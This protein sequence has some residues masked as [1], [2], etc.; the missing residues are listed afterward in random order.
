MS[1]ALLKR[2][3]RVTGVDNLN[4][5]Y[6][7]DLKRARLSRLHCYSKFSF[8]QCDIA[9]RDGMGMIVESVP[10]TTEIV[11]FAAQAGVRYSLIDPFAYQHSNLDGLMVVLEAARKISGLKHFI[12]SSSSSV[13]GGQSALPYKVVDS[14]DCPI[15][16]YAATKKAGEA[17]CHSY[18]HLY[19][20]PTTSLRFFTV[21][22]PWGRPDM[23][24][25][26]FTKNILAGEPIEVFNRG[27]M[28]RDF[29]YVDDIVSGVMSCLTLPPK[30]IEGGAPYS[31]YNLGNSR[32]EELMD[33]IGLIE[34]E[35]GKKAEIIFRPMQAGEVMETYADITDAATDFGFQPKT[36]IAE[37]LSDFIRW[38]RDFYSV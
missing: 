32:S 16:L 13:Y 8:K 10:E 38:Y 30:A 26:K 29:T 11:H 23:A 1:Q 5:Y 22:G 2:G 27:K 24:T 19:N 34:S 18:A 17:M 14:T 4:D 12:F 15:S 9:D 28:R 31:V 21:Y 37:G 7:V 3:E 35:V 33:L 25:F 36:D 6:D 20:I